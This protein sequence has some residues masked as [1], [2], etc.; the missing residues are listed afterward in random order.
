LEQS[1][2]VSALYELVSSRTSLFFTDVF[3][4]FSTVFDK[5]ITTMTRWSR[6]CHLE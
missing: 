3:P 6:T 2:R 4:Q 5:T 1:W